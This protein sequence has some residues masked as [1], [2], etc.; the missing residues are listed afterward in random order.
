[1]LDELAVNAGYRATLMNLGLVQ[2]KYHHLD[3]YVQTNGLE[4]AKILGISQEF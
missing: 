4:I 2:V 3:E 1:L